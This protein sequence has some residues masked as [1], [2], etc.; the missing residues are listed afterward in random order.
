M[1]KKIL[2]VRYQKSVAKTVRLKAIEIVRFSKKM[3]L[4]ILRK[5]DHTSRQSKN[6]L[7][8]DTAENEPSPKRC[9]YQQHRA[10]SLGQKT[11]LLR[12]MPV[13]TRTHSSRQEMT[14]SV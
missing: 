3:H 6:L 14:G 12:E 4:E 11:S 5:F 9:Q 1:R 13:R 10:P 7:S 2:N 8:L